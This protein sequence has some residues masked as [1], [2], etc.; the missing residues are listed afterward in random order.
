MVSVPQAL[1]MTLVMGVVIFFCRVFPFIFFQK[2]TSETFLSLVEKTAPPV[3]MTVL[4]FNALSG[5]IRDNVHAGIP[6][7]AAAAFTALTYLWKRN[8]LISVIGGT[9]VYMVLSRVLPST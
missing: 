7:L 5:P 3:A 6:T 8:A 4:A 1:L 9:V 2:K